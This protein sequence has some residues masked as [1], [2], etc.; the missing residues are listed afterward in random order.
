[1][2]T[3]VLDER[4]VLRKVKDTLSMQEA[5]VI[6]LMRELEYQTLTVVMEKGKVVHKKQLKT[7]KD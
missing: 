6:L 5:K 2:A 4:E 7:F 1:M 3:T